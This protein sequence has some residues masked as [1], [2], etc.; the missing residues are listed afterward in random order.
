[1]ATLSRRL[2][3]S[4][5]AG[6]RL[7]I[8]P[9]DPSLV[10]PA[11]IDLRL[12]PRILASPL[13]PEAL[14]RVI[15]LTEEN[16]T[17]AIKTGQ[18]VSVMS[19]ERL[20]LPL[21]L[22]ARFGVRS[23]LARRGVVPFGGIQLD[24]GFRGY[25]ILSLQNVGP[26]PIALRLRETLFTVEFNRLEESAE[27]ADQGAYQNQLDFPQDQYDFILKT[28]TTSLAEI[29]TLRQEVSRLNVL[30][31]ELTEQLHDPDEGLNLKP[32]VEKKLK[33]SG[34][35]ERISL[36]QMQRKLGIQ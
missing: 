8:E 5:I 6:G 35:G 7:K 11:S 22:C 20:E 13:G 18:M 29:P 14:G 30:V 3:K 34:H 25:L 21:D 26:E 36:E 28:R 33:Q 17:Y 16:S 15:V 32:E 24:P 10:E 1:M 23:S 31:Q 4:E 27:E 12:G 2:I 9:F 19:W